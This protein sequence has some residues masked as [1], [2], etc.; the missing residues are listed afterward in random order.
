MS[1]RH[2]LSCAGLAAA[3]LLLAAPTPAPAAADPD[4]PVVADVASVD[5]IVAALYDVISGPAG[6]ARDWDRFV[7]LFHPD[8]GRLVGMSRNPAGEIVYRVLTPQEYADLSGPSLEARGFFEVEIG[9][10]EHR[11]GNM[12]HRFSAYEARRTLE[13]PEP[14]MRGINSIQALHDGERWWIVTV[15][16]DQE[17]ADNPIPDRYLAGG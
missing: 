15:L 5:A 1:R 7:H 10:E 13:D 4:P 2:R 12:A 9:H 11:F 17:R 14:F 6:E 3:A 16:W 8:A